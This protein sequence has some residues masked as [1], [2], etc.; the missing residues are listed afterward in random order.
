MK[1]V[2]TGFDIERLRKKFLSE[3][4]ITKLLAT[5][6]AEYPEIHGENT[7]EFWDEKFSGDNTTLFPMAYFR[8]KLVAST[9]K[10]G[11][12]VLNLGV[13][14]GY[15]EEFILERHLSSVD[16][17]AT[18]FTDTALKNLKKRFSQIKF[19]TT[20]LVP[21]PFPSESYDVVCLLEVL[22]H[23]APKETFSVLNQIY[24]V[25]KPGGTAIISVPLNEGLEQM[26]PSN[27]NAHKRVYSIDLIIFE[28]QKA[29][30]TV[31][32]SE[33]NFCFWEFF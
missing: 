23:I 17:T 33:K 6:S 25:L 9:I 7:P 14:M 27:P 29:G 1:K 3:G 22:E 32:R 30:F 18:D 20:G 28:I 16:L 26:M 31:Y 11:D 2:I 10:S 13:G 5:Y 4:K 21:L 19:V 12:A 8:N 15:L 24:S